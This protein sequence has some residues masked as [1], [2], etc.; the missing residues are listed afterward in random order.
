MFPN[1]FFGSFKPHPRN[2]HSYPSFFNDSI[3]KSFPNS[4]PY[5]NFIPNYLTYSISQLMSSIGDRFM[6][7]SVT[8]NPPAYCY[9][10]NIVTFLYP[11]LPKN[12]AHDKEAAPAPIIAIFESNTK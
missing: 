12:V 8:T 4:F 2:T 6:G 3:V 7:I 1:P 9:F 10:S 11:N 5:T